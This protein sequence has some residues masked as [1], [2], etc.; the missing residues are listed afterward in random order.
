MEN[1]NLIPKR[2]NT[3]IEGS[4]PIDEVASSDNNHS[5]PDIISPKEKER[6]MK[7]I[8]KKTEKILRLAI[9]TKQI[10]HPIDMIIKKEKLSNQ[11]TDSTD[12]IYIE[13]EFEKTENL[14]KNI[15][16]SGEIEFQ[17]KTGRQMSYGEMRA[18]FG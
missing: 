12:T 3:P 11:T 2:S 1:S 10:L 17:E 4:K 8:E 14:L 13:K 5:L 7:S 9:E 18:M 6:I 15:M 16:K